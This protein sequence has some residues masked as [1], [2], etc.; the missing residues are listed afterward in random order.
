MKGKTRRLDNVKL[1]T[2]GA[3]GEHDSVLVSRKDFSVHE[4]LVTQSIRALIS[5]VRLLHL[6]S[7]HHALCISSL[8]LSR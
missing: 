7:L 5:R 4:T 1:Q 8:I 3:I 2:G 6:A